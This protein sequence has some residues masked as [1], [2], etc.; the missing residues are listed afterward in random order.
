MTSHH[1]GEKLAAG[2]GTLF[3]PVV[4]YKTHTEKHVSRRVYTWKS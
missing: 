1:G 4:V 2:G 3:I